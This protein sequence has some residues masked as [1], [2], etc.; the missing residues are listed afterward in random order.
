ML[1]SG[2]PYGDF[3]IVGGNG[4]ES[5][6]EVVDNSVAISPLHVPRMALTCGVE[7]GRIWACGDGTSV[8]ATS[9]SM[10]EGGKLSC[11]KL[12]LCFARMGNKIAVICPVSLV[13]RLSWYDDISPSLLQ[14]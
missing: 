14:L 10:E 7:G 4:S 13:P 9:C 6:V 3:I 11:S 1:L 12:G 5:R 2:L 8:Q